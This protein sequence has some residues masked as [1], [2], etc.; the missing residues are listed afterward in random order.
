MFGDVGGLDL[1]GKGSRG[2]RGEKEE[3][4]LCVAR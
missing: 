1:M 3:L 2:G 4:L